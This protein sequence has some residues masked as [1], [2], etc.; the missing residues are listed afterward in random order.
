MFILMVIVFIVGYAAIALEHPLKVNKSATALL[1]GVILWVLLMFG[2]E[3]LLVNTAHYKEY[4]SQVIGGDYASWLTHSALLEHLGEISE[5]IFFLLGAMTIVEL[6]DSHE[7]FAIIT[8]KIKTTKKIKL[9][10]ILSILTFFMSAA[11]DN[12]TTSIVMTA[13]LRK[14]IA[15][16]ADRWFF[17]GMVIVAANAGGAWS[18]IGD[19]TT[20]MLWIAGD[21]TTVNIIVKTLLPSL[22]SM[23]VPLA[24]LSFTMKGN[25]RSPKSASL[26]KLDHGSDPTTPFERNLIFFIGVGSLL[27]VPVFKT[28]THLP[29][30]LGMLWGLGLLWVIT[31]IIHK[32]KNENHK[33]YLS[34]VGVLRKVDVPSVLFFLGILTAVAALQTAG[35]L[36]L[37][38]DWLNVNVGNLYLINI[39]IGVLSSIVDNVPLVAAAM[40]MYNFP[41]DHYFWE[42]LAYCAGTGGSILI[43]GSAAGVAVMGMEKID[44]IW[45]LKKISLL[46][47][48][49]YLAG[50]GVYFL[51]EES[52][53]LN[54]THESNEIV[55]DLND[56]QAVSTYIFGHEFY[57][58]AGTHETEV[59]N[60]GGENG[61]YLHFVRVLEKGK[62][63]YGY[64]KKIIENGAESWEGTIHDGAYKI[65]PYKN[66][67][68]KVQI[69]EQTYYLNKAG[70]IFEKD[71]E[72]ADDFSVEWNLKKFEE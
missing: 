45:Y 58:K 31:E 65:A 50:A 30:Y 18:P 56:E 68:V 11:L 17:A 2:G 13:L 49:G 46:A 29:P 47:L 7:G 64:S 52:G 69:L 5:I 55:L 9:L 43:I 14:L 22:V 40:G 32:S 19:V 71:N 21:V 57:T 25:V 34:V 8:D 33:T 36:Y 44:F 67:M 20:I 24:I 39:I 4:L 28:V 66:N 15:D 42:F 12:L 53:L 70:Q 54:F 38:A 1:L 37:L 48:V 26:D 10:W 3:S 61:A 59:G 27:F 51:Q 63:Q 62:L 16:K 72:S 41:P 35:H 6:V 23:I 60:H